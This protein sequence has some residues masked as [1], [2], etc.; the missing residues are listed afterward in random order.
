MNSHSVQVTFDGIDDLV[1]TLVELSRKYPDR[2]SELLQADA[3]IL[4]KDVVSRIKKD[5]ET[6]KQSKRSLRK[7]G[8]YKISQPRDFGCMQ[9]IEISAT[10]PHFHLVEHGHNKTN[11]KGEVIGFVEGRRY[12]ADAVEEFEDNIE[13]HVISMI[14]ALLKEG[15]LI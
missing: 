10:S 2:A 5:A 3:K 14:D 9:Y 4:R 1:D 11:R 6:K 13:Y 7:A 12:M 8:S 15:D